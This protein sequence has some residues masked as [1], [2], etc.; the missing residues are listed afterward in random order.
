MMVPGDFVFIPAL[1][2]FVEQQRNAHAHI[3]HQW[4]KNHHHVCMTLDGPTWNF[5]DH[6]TSFLGTL[7]I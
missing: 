3:I 5:V 6:N 2:P 1:L 4:H 7:E